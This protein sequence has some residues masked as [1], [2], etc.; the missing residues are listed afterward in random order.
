[1]KTPTKT[2]IIDQIA[3][4]NLMERGK[5]SA[6]TFHDR[7]PHAPAHF[8]LQSWE[9][10]KNY[11][12][13]VTRDQLPLVQQA[14]AGFA[15]FQQLTRQLVEMVITDT[16]QQLLEVRGGA[17]KKPSHPRS[18]WRKSRKSSS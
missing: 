12:R 18:S 3:Q 5:L 8:K 4:I 17:K 13:H 11:T 1:M 10:G 2:Q 6:C 14:L 15:Q 16:R 7:S 9:N